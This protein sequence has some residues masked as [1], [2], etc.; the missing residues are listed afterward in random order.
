MPRPERSAVSRVRENRTHGLN[1]SFVETH[2][3]V[4]E[5]RIYQ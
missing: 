3:R 4:G 2:F 1:G 5:S